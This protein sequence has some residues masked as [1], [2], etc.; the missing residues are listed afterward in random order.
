M[1]HIILWI[2]EIIGICLLV[3]LGLA[4]CLV[5]LALFVPIRYEI[6]GA[7]E[8][9]K[10]TKEFQVRF[11]WFVY[12]I[13]GQ[14]NYNDGNFDTKIRILGFPLRIRQGKKKEPEHKTTKKGRKKTYTF[15][16]ICDKIKEIRAK[17]DCV[18]T[19]L[20]D[21]EHQKAFRLLKKVCLRLVRYLRP[22]KLEG[23]L[24]FGFEDPY[25]TGKLLAYMSMLYPW[26][27]DDIEIQPDFEQAVFSGK[28][29]CKGFVQGISLLVFLARLFMNES[30]MKTYKDIK[31]LG[32]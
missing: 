27:G 7:Y 10:N 20:S 15:R 5:L 11:R 1:I 16:G 9:E 13:S 19:F 25:L 28:G 32:L 23:S 31:R 12:L 8:R 4:L 2:L 14:A 26:Y 24:H 30:V 18:T 6:C 21:T 3:L 17:K 22:K 29:S